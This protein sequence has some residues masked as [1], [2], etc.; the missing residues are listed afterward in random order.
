M[1]TKEKIDVAI[2]IINLA[3]LGLTAW[4]IYRSIYSPIKA[5]QVGRDLNDEQNKDAAKRQLFLTLFAYRG[6]PLHQSF[7]ENLN[8]IDIV[9]HQEHAVLDS[10]HK[11]YKELGIKG[12]ADDQKVWE[13]HRVELLS[14][15]AKA[16]GYGELK[17]TDILQ[18]YY[19]EAH[20]MQLASDI[21]LRKEISNFLKSGYI[22]HNILFDYLKGNMPLSQNSNE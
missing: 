20:D 8:K 18:P 5:V 9:F 7:V 16:L 2:A 1:T 15:M 3:I 10:W 11:Y 21:E 14:E 19:P 12:R 22:V 4:F 6:L 17:Q 13:I